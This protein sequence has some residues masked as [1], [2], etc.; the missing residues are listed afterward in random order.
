ML[1]TI[2]ATADLGDYWQCGLVIAKGASEELQRKGIGA[3]RA[4][5]AEVA[6]FLKSRLAELGRLERC[7]APDRARQPVA[8]VVSDG[9]AVHR[10]FSPCNVAHWR[11]W[12]QPCDSGRRC[13]RQHPG[14]SLACPLHRRPSPR[15]SSAPPSFRN[16]RNSN[17]PGHYSN[18]CLPVPAGTD[19]HGFSG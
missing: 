13:R 10:R 8:A 4:E 7:P 3:L 5:I 19:P 18:E 17:V 16:A 11:S 6:P 9:P 12:D 2:L 1:E 14:G 15:R